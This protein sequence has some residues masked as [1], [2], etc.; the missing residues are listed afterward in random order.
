MLMIVLHFDIRCSN[1]NLRLSTIS[2]PCLYMII[3]GLSLSSEVTSVSGLMANFDLTTTSCNILCKLVWSRETLQ[4]HPCIKVFV[5][6]KGVPTGFLCVWGSILTSINTYVQWSCLVFI[7][8]FRC[9]KYFENI[10]HIISRKEL[11]GY[12]IAF[13]YLFQSWMSF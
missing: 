11:R 9:M 1:Q 4:W 13:A 12:S 3:F 2:Y 10:W 6:S 8:S 5:I 7:S